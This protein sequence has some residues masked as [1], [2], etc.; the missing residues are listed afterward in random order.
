MVGYETQNREM[1]SVQMRNIWKRFPGVIANHGINLELY[2]GEV[3]TLLGEIGA[4]KTTLMNI[5]AGGY[6]PDEGEILVDGVKVDIRSPRSAIDLGIGMVHQHFR[7][8]DTMTVAE[9]VYL[10]WDNAPWHISRKDLA[11]RLEKYTADLGFAVDPKAEIWQLSVGEQQRAE[12]LRSLVRGAKILILDEPT[13]VLT[14]SEADELFV[15]IRKL[16][17]KGHTVV[18][19]SHKLNEVLEI[20]DQVTILR[21]GENVVTRR[22]DECNQLQLAHWMV[23]KQM[24]FRCFTKNDHPGPV[25]AEMRQVNALNDRKLP[26]LKDINLAVR[27]GEILG[28]AGVSGN[29]QTELAEVMTGMRPSQSGS[30]WIEGINLTGRSARQYSEVGEG[31]I[32]EDRN[33]MGLFPTLSLTHNA[34]LREYINPPIRKGMRLDNKTAEQ[35][36]RKLIQLGDVRTPDIHVLASSLS[37]GNQQKLLVRR[38]IEISSHLLVAVHP[39]RGLDI[40]ATEDVRCALIEHRDAGNALILISEDLDEILM[41]SDRIAVMYEGR[42]VGVFTS[43]EANRDEIGL[44]MGGHVDPRKNQDD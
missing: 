23:G 36:A 14:P 17:A 12:I 31:H 2:A 13:A 40:G 29:G 3:H 28:I 25:V 27:R 34:I 16:K 21:G 22:T 15:A 38:E 41:M 9:N 10:G 19:I 33:G 6:P 44:L 32:P 7:L 37:G 18:F 24:E 42:I 26:A 35:R 30:I 4:G 39:T 43:L 1:P 8:I 5:L 20:S 11:R